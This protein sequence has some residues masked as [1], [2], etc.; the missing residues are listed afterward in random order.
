MTPPLGLRPIHH[1]KSNRI[2]GHLFIS[3]LAYHLL[4]YNRH[5][6]QKAGLNH[7]WPTIR[8]WLETHEVLTTDLPK[9]GG[10]VIHLRYCTIPTLKQQQI[11][12]ALRITSIPLRRKK[13]ETRVFV[14]CGLRLENS[15]C[16]RDRFIAFLVPACPVCPVPGRICLPSFLPAKHCLPYST[17]RSQRRRTGWPH[18]M[19][20]CW[21]KKISIDGVI[22]VVY[23]YCY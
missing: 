14:L 8:S 5:R 9:E 16:F 17:N 1:S 11:Y 23:R 22:P 6:M 19:L 7:R 18:T 15:T 20:C 10:G 12:K 4:N 2:E 3:V 13:T 21:H